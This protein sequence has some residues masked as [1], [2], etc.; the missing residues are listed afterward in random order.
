MQ[1]TEGAAVRV[2]VTLADLDAGSAPGA[3]HFA[4][5]PEGAAETVAAGTEGNTVSFSAASFSVYGIVDAPEPVPSSG[6]N[7]VSSLEELAL[8]GGAGLLMH[9]PDGYYFRD[10]QYTVKGTRTGIR[11]T[12]PPF[13]SPAAAAEGT[14]ASGKAA[15][16]YFEPVEGENNRYT[17]YCETANGRRYVR[18]NSDSLSLVGEEQATV[19]TVEAFPG[20]ANTFRVLGNDQYWNMQGGNNGNGFAANSNATDVNARIQLEY[21]FDQGDDPYGLDGQTYGIA[22]HDQSV[23]AAALTAEAKTSGNQQRRL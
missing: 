15:L 8:Y 20:Q 7:R 10:E 13:S 4:G 9:H 18:Q 5:A 21:Y 16:Y 6:W 1:P 3:V 17:V 12:K 19:F 22:F 23:T 14:A 2:D 11:K